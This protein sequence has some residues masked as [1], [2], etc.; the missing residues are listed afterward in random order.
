MLKQLII[1]TV[2]LPPSRNRGSFHNRASPGL[3]GWC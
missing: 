1:A 3:R 2:L